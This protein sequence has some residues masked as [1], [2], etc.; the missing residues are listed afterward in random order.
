MLLASFAYA[1]IKVSDDNL[2]RRSQIVIDNLKSRAYGPVTP[3]QIAAASQP[4]QLI[5]FLEARFAQTPKSDRRIDI[6]VALVRLG[7]RDD[8]YWNI[9]ANLATPALK[10]EAPSPRSPEYRAWAKAHNVTAGSA[11][12]QALYNIWQKILPLAF[13]GDPRSI[14]LLRKG[15]QSPNTDIQAEAAEGLARDHD[16]SSIP[17]I[18]AALNQASPIQ[19][20]PL[21]GTLKYFDDDAQAKAV[22]KKYFPTLDPLEAFERDTKGSHDGEISLGY[23]VERIAR[24]HEVQAIPLLEQVFA[25]RRNRTLGVGAMRSKLPSTSDQSDVGF[26][27]DCLNLQ[28]ELHIA[29]VLIRLGVKDVVYWNYLAEQAQAALEINIPFPIK[30]DAQEGPNPPPN[31][32]F[33][34]WVR[35]RNLDRNVTA[36]YE[37]MYLPTSVN[38]LAMTDDPRG[39]PLLRQALLSANPMIQAVAAQGLASLQDK[40]SIPQIIAACKK[41]SASERTALARSLV[42]FDDPQARA[43][44]ELNVPAT[45]FREL[46]QAKA[47]G[48]TPFN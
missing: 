39:I 6:A 24:V 35:S 17:L 11:E 9:I 45:T 26:Q 19:A 32:E 18:I 7:D 1:Q 47:Q 23:D 46:L 21:A 48:H 34:A 38:L 14:P 25:Q 36:M 16:K 5:P 33:A 27:T 42:Y 44:A 22:V 15:L 20:R 13:T 40:D 31:P 37:L 28:I 3:A 12:E 43:F 29:S 2:G 4:G 41:A 10:S 30:T 8:T